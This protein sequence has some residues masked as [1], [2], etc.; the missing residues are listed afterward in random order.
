[1][2]TAVPFIF[3]LR[4]L[5]AA[6]C[7]LAAASPVLAQTPRVKVTAARVGLPPGGRSAERDENGSPLHLCK[8]AAWSPVYVELQILQAVD[9]PAELVIETPDPDEITTTLAVPINLAGVTPG[10][11]VRAWTAGLMPYIR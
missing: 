2:R 11:E 10:T 4:T 5:A 3:P 6:V 1:M 8:F 7:L 9:E